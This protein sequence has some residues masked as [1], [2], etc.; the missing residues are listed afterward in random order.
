MGECRVA[1]LLQHMVRR[2]LISYQ[3]SSPKE[4]HGCNDHAE[5]PGRDCSYERAA[6]VMEEIL[7]CGHTFRSRNDQEP[8]RKTNQH[9]IQKQ[10]EK[11]EREDNAKG[12]QEQGNKGNGPT[13]LLLQAQRRKSGD[14]DY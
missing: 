5:Y 11:V 4:Y 7:V 6:K 1:G 9:P 12:I 3:H 14:G 10:I 13:P 8:R 2:G